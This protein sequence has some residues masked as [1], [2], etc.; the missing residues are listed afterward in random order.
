MYP[1]HWKSKALL[2]KLAAV[3]RGRRKEVEAQW[4]KQRRLAKAPTTS[5][6]DFTIVIGMILVLNGAKIINIIKRNPVAFVLFED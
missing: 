4:R 3:K 2:E 5:S 1:H 6:F